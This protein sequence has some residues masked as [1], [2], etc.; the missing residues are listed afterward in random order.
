MTAISWLSIA[1]QEN[2][3]TDTVIVSDFYS[4]V[5]AE[6]RRA[7]IHLPL[8]YFKDSAKQYPV[9]Y[10]LDGTS[11][12]QHT[13]D[14]LTVL[15]D[16]G[17]LPECIVVGIPNVRGSRNRDQTPPFMQTEVED[18]K[19]PFGKGDAFLDFIEKELIPKI[20]S[21]YR[22]TGYKTISGHSRG[23]LFVLYTLLEKPEL[24]NARFSYSAPAWRFDDI[25]VKKVDTLLRSRAIQKKTFLFMSVGEDEN[26]DIM[27]AFKK[28]TASLEKH[29]QKNISWSVFL[30]PHANHQENPLV[31]TA[32]GFVEWSKYL[33]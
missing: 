14:K 6:K 19:S 32:R 22:T 10:V 31:S 16:G 28:L 5:L 24:F 3:K 23:A 13:M 30:A 15:S 11:Q 25:L 9:M 2:Y 7:I 1:A 29:K 27:S 8:N 33:R 18:P 21:N 17:L 20:D 12:D 4:G 26:K